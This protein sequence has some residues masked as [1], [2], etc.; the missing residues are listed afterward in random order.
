MK[1]LPIP[2]CD[3]CPHLTVN[4]ISYKWVCKKRNRKI[5]PDVTAIP[6]WCPLEDAEKDD[7]K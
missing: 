6:D 5:V 4:P 1:N 3:E 2:S 7:N